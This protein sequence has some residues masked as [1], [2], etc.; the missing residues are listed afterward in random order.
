MRRSGFRQQS[1]EEVR[2][3]QAKKRTR[4]PL[5][6]AKRPLGA[7]QNPKPRKWTKAAAKRRKK[8]IWST[9]TADNYFSKWVRARDGKCLRCQRTDNLTCSHYKRRAISITRFDPENCIAL[10]A[11]CHREWE[12]PKEGYTDFM[13]SWLGLDKFV[14]LER[15]A[16][17]HMAR[18]DAVAECKAFLKSF[19]PTVDLH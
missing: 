6:R 17:R 4:T 2:E 9:A 19:S 15:R 10:C 16:G 1:I 7:A 14:E 12:G 11:D 18:P 5:K 3:K 8:G 13:I